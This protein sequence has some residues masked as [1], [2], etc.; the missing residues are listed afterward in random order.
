LNRIINPMR[1]LSKYELFIFDWDHTL[2]TSTLVVTLI[3]LLGARRRR[4]RIEQ[5]RNRK[6]SEFSAK[7][8]EIKEDVSKV[9][10]AFDDIYGLLFRPR[11]KRNA[12]QLLRLLKQNGKKVAIF[13]DSKAYRLL[14]ETEA[15]G[16]MKYVDFA[17]SAESIGY[18]KPDPT[19]LLALVDRFR[20]PKRKTLYI[21]DM[22]GDVLAARLAGIDSCAVADGMGSLESL[23]R[24]RP[25]Y[26]FARL[27]SFL[28][29]LKSQSRSK[30]KV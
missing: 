8:V 24:E 5:M 13:S 17:L 19:G 6:P 16:V 21:G 25:D 30:T 4:A 29:S 23:E 27:G 15:L 7:N 3:H 2:T 14:R 22:A 26:A 20:V 9:Y 11:L 18:F 28:Q 10:S 1:I 12:V